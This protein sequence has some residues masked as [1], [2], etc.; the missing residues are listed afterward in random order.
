MSF[1]KNVLLQ[2]LSA[3]E[4]LMNLE[5]MHWDFKPDNIFIVWLNFPKTKIKNSYF[6]CN[7]SFQI[8]IG[9]FEF[10][11]SANEEC[12]RTKEAGA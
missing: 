8:K 2:I 5:I 1:F 7:S 6:D 12:P 3:I 9:D 10:G 4:I 11:R